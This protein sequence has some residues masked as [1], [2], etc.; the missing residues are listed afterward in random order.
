MTTD[1]GLLAKAIGDPNRL[2]ILHGLL[3]GPLCVCE[4]GDSLMMAQSTLSSH[5]QVLRESGLVE[6]DRSGKWVVY[7][8]APGALEVLSPLLR[9]LPEQEGRNLVRRDMLRLQHRLDLRQKGCC[10][11]G[12]GGLDKHLKEVHAMSDK[13]ACKCGCCTCDSCQC[14]CC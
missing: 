6:D 11:V 5:L 4:V 8:I 7:R 13:E 1:I 3:Q 14:G 10:V 12:F 2:R 9:A